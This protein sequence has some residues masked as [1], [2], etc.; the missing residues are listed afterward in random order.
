MPSGPP[1]AQRK[2]R[3][4][5]TTLAAPTATFLQP[6]VAETASLAIDIVWPD[7][8]KSAMKLARRFFQPRS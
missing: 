7:A 6:L 4:S 2:A 8:I 5:A 1:S 3:R